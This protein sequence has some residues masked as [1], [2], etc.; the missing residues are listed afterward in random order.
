MSAM[1]LEMILDQTEMRMWYVT[2]ASCMSIGILR[3]VF[4]GDGV[5]VVIKHRTE[6]SILILLMTL[7]FTIK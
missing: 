3:L 1:I 2:P 6:D 4:I 5:R 7:S